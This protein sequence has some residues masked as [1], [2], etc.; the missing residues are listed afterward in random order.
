MSALRAYRALPAASGGWFLVVALLGR[1]PSAMNQIGSLLLVSHTTGSLAAGGAT[2]AS[3]ALGQAVGGPLV[4]RLADRTGHR[5]IGAAIAALQ[6]VAIVG[7]VALANA[8]APLPAVLASGFVVGL[9]VP[10]VGPLARARWSG[11]VECG[12]APASAFGTAMSYEGAADET[13]YVLGPALVGIVVAGSSP[14]AAMLLAAALTAVFALAFALHPTASLVHHHDRAAGTSAG[15][16][17]LPALLLLSVILVCVG[18]FFASVQAGVT[19]IAIAAGSEGTAGV[20]YAVM[21]LTSAAAGLLTPALPHRFGLPARL[22]SFLC[23]LL[24]FVTPL[25]ALGATGSRSLVALGLAVAL[26]GVA[27][28]PTLITAYSLAERTVPPS[29]VSWA[30]TMLSSGVVLGYAIAA[31]AAGVLAQ[32]HGAIGAFAVTTGAVAA[33]VLLSL[34][35]WRRFTAVMN[36]RDDGDVLVVS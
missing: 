19:S 13:T 22:V 35:G 5:R 8:G 16:R 31:L 2:A 10:Q 4:G 21:G 33:G 1:L 32:Q 6:V 14:Q 15:R 11:L 25:L 28:A 23:L 12:R 18:A 7:L 24:L 29:Q 9:T 3:L 20:I 26:A 17:E 27:V 34:L 36:R 30:M